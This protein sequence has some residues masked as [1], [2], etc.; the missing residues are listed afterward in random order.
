MKK[1]LL[2]AV[3]MLAVATSHGQSPTVQQIDPAPELTED[4]REAVFIIQR[5]IQ[6]GIEMRQQAQASEAARAID[7]AKRRAAEILQ[8]VPAAPAALPR[9][10]YQSVEATQPGDAGIYTRARRFV[11]SGGDDG[12]ASSAQQPNPAPRARAPKA[13]ANAR[14]MSQ[15]PAATL[16]RPNVAYARPEGEVGPDGLRQLASHAISGR[17][18]SR[19]IPMSEE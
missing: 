6:R 13:A 17:P 8:T 11:E 15:N 1:V 10:V 7:A 5:Q 12:W 3:F 18:V 4:Q 14:P 16:E 9:Q 2:A 19:A